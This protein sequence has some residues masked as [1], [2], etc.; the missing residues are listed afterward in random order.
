ML[1]VF[2]ICQAYVAGFISALSV[3]LFE[4]TIDTIEELAEST[5][6]VSTFLNNVQ[7]RV[8]ASTDPTMMKLAQRYGAHYNKDEAYFNASAGDMIIGEPRLQIEYR[9]YRDYADEFGHTNMKI[10]KE[11]LF[12][13]PV[14]ITLQKDSLYTEYVNEGIQLVVESGLMGKWFQDTLDQVGKV[15]FTDDLIDGDVEALKREDLLGH[16]LLASIMGTFSLLTF[17]SELVYNIIIARR[18]PPI[19]AMYYNSQIKKL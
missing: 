11:C 9:I 8:R 19:V 6:P 1:M 18:N 2:V 17:I 15:R 12:T 7:K 13:F 4:K 16:F 5:Q 3:P 10:M 14:G